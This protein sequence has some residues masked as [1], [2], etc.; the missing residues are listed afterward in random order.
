MKRGGDLHLILTRRRFADGVIDYHKTRPNV[1]YIGHWSV[2]GVIATASMVGLNL[3]MTPQ[4][5]QER[6]EARLWCFF[7]FMMT[8]VSIGLASWFTVVDGGDQWPSLSLVVQ[9]LLLLAAG[10]LFFFRNGTRVDQ[11]MF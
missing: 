3:G 1:D 7:T 5:V 10:L 2:P 9:T 8:F 6:W 11:G 4:H